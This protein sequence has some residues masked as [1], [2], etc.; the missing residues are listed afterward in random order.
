MLI[1]ERAGRELEPPSNL[2]PIGMTVKSS[3]R[4]VPQNPAYRSA[5]LLI[6]A[7]PSSSDLADFVSRCFFPDSDLATSS[8]SADGFI[9]RLMIFLAFSIAYFCMMAWLVFTATGEMK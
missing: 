9:H 1:A 4:T 5:S 6:P 2:G 7:I 8:S 3:A